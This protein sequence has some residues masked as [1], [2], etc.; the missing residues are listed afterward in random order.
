M[1]DTTATTAGRGAGSG[2]RSAGGPVALLVVL[3]VVLLAGVAIVAVASDDSPEVVTVEIPAGT[4]ER[5]DAGE[6]VEVVDSVVHVETGGSV[7]LVNDDVRLHVLGDLR[8]DPGETARLAFPT[9]GRYI[10][11]TSL[12]SDAQT[13]IL[14][15]DPPED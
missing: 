7:E 15:E 14:V 8:V 1:T 10:V 3:A 5:L 6:V 11:A 9:E 4:A 13:T 2:A 12:R